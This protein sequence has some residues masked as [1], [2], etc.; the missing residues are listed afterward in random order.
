VLTKPGRR[1]SGL[2]GSLRAFRQV[3]VWT[4]ST[5]GNNLR[6][7]GQYFDAETGLHYNWAPLLRFR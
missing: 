7:A 3:T 4:G 1:E 6:F 5:V 2:A